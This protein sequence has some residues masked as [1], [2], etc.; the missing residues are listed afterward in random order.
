ME[1]EKDLLYDFSE[2]STD[3]IPD[4][5]YLRRDDNRFLSLLRE[6]YSNIL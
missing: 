4:Q 3:E 6:N 5:P 2:L 1:K